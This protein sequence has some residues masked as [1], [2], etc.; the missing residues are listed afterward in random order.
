[1]GLLDHAAYLGD[2]FHQMELR[3][4]AARSVGEHHVDLAGTGGVDGVEH[5]RCRIAG[6]LGDDDDAISFAPG[7]QLLAGRGAKGVAGG[8]QNALALALEVLGQLADGSGFAGAVDARNHDHERLVAAGV[9]RLFKWREQG[10][11]A[12]GQSR[13]QLGGGFQLVALDRGLE[14]GQQPVCRVDAAIRH[15]QCGFQ[16]VEQLVVDLR[17]TE[18]LGQ[19]GVERVAGAGKAALEAFAP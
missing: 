12:L 11:Q 9:Q 16:I 15:Q 6:F 7:R 3:R 18:E 14:F 4:Q 5:H 2:F 19:R 10:L 17:P 13:T 8:Q 1:M